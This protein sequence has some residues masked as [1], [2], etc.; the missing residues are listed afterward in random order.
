MAVE[1]VYRHF[2]T[3]FLIVGFSMKL[4]HQRGSMDHSLRYHWLTILS[5]LILIVV[6]SGELWAAEDPSR[7]CVRLLCCVI[8]YIVAATAELSI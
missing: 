8:V 7:R 4:W 1:L 2:L 5:T 3:L 6:D